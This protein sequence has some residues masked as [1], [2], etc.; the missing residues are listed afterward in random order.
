MGDEK[1]V[2]EMIKIAF[3]IYNEIA[4]DRLKASLLANVTLCAPIR[5]LYNAGYRRV[6]PNCGAKMKGGEE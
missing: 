3:P 2:E 5:N 4:S 1:Q 6:C